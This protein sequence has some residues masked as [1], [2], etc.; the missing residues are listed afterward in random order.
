MKGRN[1]VPA[2]WLRNEEFGGFRYKIVTER[3]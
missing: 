3:Y 2:R 1:S